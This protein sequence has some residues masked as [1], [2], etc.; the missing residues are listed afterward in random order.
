MDQN[1][2]KNS[3]VP[4][5]SEEIR[6]LTYV[7]LDT[8]VRFDLP[9][10]LILK[11]TKN[12]RKSEVEACIDRGINDAMSNGKFT[13]SSSFYFLNYTTVYDKMTKK[14]NPKGLCFVFFEDP[15]FP[16]IFLGK[17][18]NGSERVEVYPD[19]GL[20]PKALGWW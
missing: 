2:S 7:D 9:N 19:P 15:G 20:G 1:L 5:V 10:V 6:P 13:P 16:Q 4:E 14:T 11:K 18:P 3:E 17:N 8:H 12:L